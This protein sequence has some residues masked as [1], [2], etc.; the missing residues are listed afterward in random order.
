MIKNTGGF[1]KICLAV[2]FPLTLV[3]SWSV[4]MYVYAQKS[5]NEDQSET[6]KQIKFEGLHSLSVQELESQLPYSAGEVWKN[7]YKGRLIEYVS[8]YLQKRGFYNSKVNAQLF[9]GPNG[10]ELTFQI[11]EGK[12]CIIRSFA[13]DNP[14]GFKS[15]SALL[16]FKKRMHDVAELSEGDR[17]DEQVVA[18][19]LRQLR[20]WLQSENFILANTDQVRLTFNDNH[21]LV[22]VVAVVEYGDRVT[23]GF[24]GNKVFTKGELNDMISELKTTGLGKDY[25]GIIERKFVEEYRV[26]AFN[27]IKIETRQTDNETSKH[28]SFIFSEGERT[29]IESVRWE[30]LSPENTR[31]A[32][33]T[34]EEG[35]SR[36]VER[37]YYV[38]RDVDKAIEHVLEDLKS[39]GY[40]AAKYITKNVIRIPVKKTDPFQNIVRITVQMIEGEQ[41]FVGRVGLSG[42]HFIKSEEVKEFFKTFEDQPFNPFALEEGIQKLQ[43]H[44]IS[45]GYLQFRILTKED[46][47]VEF[48][49]N[50]RIANIEFAI[51]EGPRIKVGYI[52]IKG[53][54]K[55]RP[56]I[57]E[58]EYTVQT[59]DW[60]TA[61][62]V[63]ELESNLRKLGLFSEISIAPEPSNKGIEYRDM[64]IRLKEAEPGLLEVGPGFRSDLGARAFARLSYA[65]IAGR[66]WIGA[67]SAEGNRRFGSQYKF[68]EYKLDISFVNPRIFDSRFLYTLGFQTKKQRFPPDFN[69]SATQFYTGFERKIIKPLTV[70][71]FYKLERIRQFDVYVN[72]LFSPQD[73]QSMLIG[74]VIPTIVL[75]T[76][77]NPLTA[78]KGQLTTLSLEYADPSFSGQKRS[79]KTAAGFQRWNGSTHWYIPVTKEIVWSNVVA[80]GFARSNIPN[81]PIPLIKLFRLG[82]YNTIRG[83]GEDVIN[84]DTTS[85][86]GTLTY[87]NLRT[88]VD[89]PF[90][91]DLKFA[92]FLDAG[93]L[94]ID[95]V[96]RNNPFFRAGA[97]AGLHYMTP[98]GPVNLDWGFKLN[99]IGNETPSQIHFSVG[100]I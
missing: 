79:D 91:G 9:S 37:G 64:V 100:L 20:E 90:I 22:D 42:F 47:I 18:D 29:R 95:N 97:G 15:K 48:T 46:V 32:E 66:N 19:K 26:R 39:R 73:N 2:L 85:F 98:V 14:P 43:S 54:E 25:I 53:L 40:L 65:N 60:W 75:D 51:S 44:Y 99:Q 49:E 67:F 23:F 61:E 7:S 16:R 71:L 72:G 27:D 24:R 78:T 92:P 77:E 62:K 88:Q 63:S 11:D 83:F 21:T 34:F 59:E 41:T 58:R 94:F 55:T 57:V 31:A 12:S 74:S 13:I 50:N 38:E 69:A 5:Q 3:G 70:K 87:V 33:N 84:V 56:N 6:V 96:Y 82:G 1:S 80:G 36:L 8:A 10:L 28:I 4:P 45:N 93:N 52:R 81:R 76:R 35:V 86:R 89:L 68:P 17:Y 30:G